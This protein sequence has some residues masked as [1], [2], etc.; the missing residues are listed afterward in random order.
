M[1]LSGA[2][3]SAIEAL[4]ANLSHDQR[5][6]LKENSHKTLES[7]SSYSSIRLMDAIDRREFDLAVEAI[8]RIESLERRKG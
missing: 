2:E 8:V 7:I 1:P 4:V 6:E 5:E 3:Q